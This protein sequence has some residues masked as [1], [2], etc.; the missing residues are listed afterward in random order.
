[1]SEDYSLHVVGSTVIFSGDIEH[2]IVSNLQS[3]LLDLENQKSGNTDKA[4]TLFISSDGGRVTEGLKLRD[5]LQRLN[6]DL[7]IVAEGYLASAGILVLCT[8]HKTYATE[9]TTFLLHDIWHCSQGTL[10][11]SKS[12]LQYSELLM[13]KILTLYNSRTKVVITKEMLTLDWF[14]DVHKAI[15]LG[16][17]DGIYNA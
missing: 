7:T 2:E 4:V 8:K 16:L 12:R 14:F 5:F 9:N 6:L 11:N 17:V 13:T 1:M 10:E 3:K 15:E